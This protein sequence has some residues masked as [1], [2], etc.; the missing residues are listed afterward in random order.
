MEGRRPPALELGASSTPRT[1]R[2]CPSICATLRVSGPPG[3]GTAIDADTK[4]GPSWLV[5]N[6][7]RPRWPRGSPVRFLT[8]SQKLLDLPPNPEIGA[9]ATSCS[10]P[11]IGG[12]W[13][14]LVRPSGSSRGR[15]GR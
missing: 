5:V 2:T 15:G 6:A 4:L 13:R 3:G 10:V 8:Q 7:P 12:E 9:A 14:H 1:R 11:A